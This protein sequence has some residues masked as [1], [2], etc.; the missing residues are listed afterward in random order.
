[1]NSSTSLALVAEELGHGHA[2]QADA[3][4][5]A[6]RLVHLAEDQRHL[7]EHARLVHLVVQVVALAGALAHAGE[8]GVAAVLVGD[9]ADQ[10]LDDD[11]LAH[12]GAAEDADLAALAERGDQVDDLDA[13]LER[14]RLDRLVDQ[15]RRRAVDRVVDVVHD[16]AACRRSARRAR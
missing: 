3:L 4:A 5:H 15:R 2:R 12:A 10:L 6:R 7:V 16:R 14:A 13:G 9:V 8:D 1:M 11:R